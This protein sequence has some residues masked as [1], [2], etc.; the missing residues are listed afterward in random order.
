MGRA[1]DEK[2]IL[3]IA[4]KT[5]K[6]KGVKGMHDLKSYYVGNKFHI[7]IHIE[8]DK[9]K[10]TEVSHDIGEAVRN[11]IMKLPD[12]SQAFVHIDPV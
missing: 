6:V 7:E 10:T 12:I 3:E 1:A 5:L 2:T 11:E 4:N 8:V 9:D